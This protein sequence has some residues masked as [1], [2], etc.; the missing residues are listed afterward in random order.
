M[1]DT[2]KILKV[3]LELAAGYVKFAYSVA[4]TAWLSARVKALEVLI[5]LQHDPNPAIRKIAR[6]LSR[7]E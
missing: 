2:L 5:A 7:K 4:L 6:A 1:K 3:L